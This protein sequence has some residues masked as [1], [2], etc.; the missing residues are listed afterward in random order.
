MYLILTNQYKLFQDTTVLDPKPIK[1]DR[2][3]DWPR[4]EIETQNQNKERKPLA[5]QS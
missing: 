1:T 2:P 3:A 5:M 4:T